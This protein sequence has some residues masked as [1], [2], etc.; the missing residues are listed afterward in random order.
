MKPHGPSA[1]V[2]LQFGA[3]RFHLG[4]KGEAQHQLSISVHCSRSL[5]STVHGCCL[6]GCEKFRF[7]STYPF[8]LTCSCA[9]AR[10]VPGS[11]N[12]M[13]VLKETGHNLICCFLSITGVHDTLLKISCSTY[14]LLYCHRVQN[15]KSSSS[16]FIRAFI[17]NLICH[18]SN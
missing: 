4:R 8:C 2:S 13:R 16:A 7:F 3:N 18:F 5:L 15:R 12:L 11:L 1:K 9:W 6:A 17:A 14:W 10:L